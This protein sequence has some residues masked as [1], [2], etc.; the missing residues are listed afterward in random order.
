VADQDQAE[1][2]EISQNAGLGQNWSALGL[3]AE[4]Y[5][6]ALQRQIAKFPQAFRISR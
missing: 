5:E 6:P 4:E 2:R 3:L 1:D